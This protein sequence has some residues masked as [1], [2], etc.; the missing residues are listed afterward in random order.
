MTEHDPDN[1][2]CPQNDAQFC[3]FNDL[4][5]CACEPVD[6]EQIRES[7]APG[8]KPHSESACS[9]DRCADWIDGRDLLTLVD[10]QA[11]EIK[12]L[13]DANK[14]Y[15][16]PPEHRITVMT[17]EIKRLNHK[18]SMQADSLTF[19][20]GKKAQAA[21]IKRLTKELE[22]VKAERDAAKKRIDRAMEW[23]DNGEPL[24]AVYSV[25][26]GSNKE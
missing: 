14:A 24:A 4:V 18:L 1:K 15:Q 19:L 8:T 5:L 2:A 21:E 9:C 10:T 23:L 7:Y 12:R 6:A 16:Y 13:T 11:A 20:D 3:H 22:Q 25:L 17:A 26:Q